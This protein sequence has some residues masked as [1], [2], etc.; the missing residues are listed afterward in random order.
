MEL[1]DSDEDTQPGAIAATAV[2]DASV[3]AATSDEDAPLTSSCAANVSAV[4]CPAPDAAGDD[5]QRGSVGPAVGAA[6]DERVESPTVVSVDAAS[7]PELVDG[8][9]VVAPAAH[10][11]VDSLAAG[12]VRVVAGSRCQDEDEEADVDVQMVLRSRCA[13]PT[14]EQKLD[15]A[16]VEDFPTPMAKRRRVVN[17]GQPEPSEEA[18]QQQRNVE[19]DSERR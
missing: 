7:A 4:C 8:S 3:G 10:V 6:A 17:D 15:M 14:L 13:P 1:D 16:A 2:G 18:H 11:D 12:G 19:E 5:Q 9:P